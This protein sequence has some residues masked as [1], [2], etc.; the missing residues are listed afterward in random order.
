MNLPK[1]NKYPK[2]VR[3]ASDEWKIRFVKR[4]PKNTKG[5]CDP[6]SETIKIGLNQSD[7]E[8]FRTFIHE[9]LHAMEYSYARH[10]K[11]RDIHWLEK[12]ISDFLLDNF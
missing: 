7:K 1:P 6:N 10:M 12:T 3:V 11:H 9:C 5:E 2:T 4:L 8:I